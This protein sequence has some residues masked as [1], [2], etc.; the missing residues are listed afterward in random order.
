M[1]F[2]DLGIDGF[3]VWSGLEVRELGPGLNV[4]YG[5]N[6]AGKTTLL[7]F[8]RAVLYGF[9]LERRRKYLPPVRGGQGGGWLVVATAEGTF[10]ITRT[11]RSDSLLGDVTV[12]AADGTVQGG[13]QLHDLLG[14]VDEAIF[15]NVFAVGLEELQELGTLDGTEAAR[16]L[17]GLSAGLDRVSLAE[18]MRELDASRQRLLAADER[19]S[20]IAELS[21]ERDKLCAE[22][23]ELAGSTRRYWQLE[24]GSRRVGVTKSPMP[25]PKRLDSTARPARSNWLMHSLRNG[26][27]ARCSKSKWPHWARWQVFRQTHCDEC[28]ESPTAFGSIDGDWYGSSAVG[29]N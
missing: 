14:D 3:G 17:Y 11:A 26:T 24:R 18:V 7:Q 4:F 29:D 21:A 1:K 27:S 5:P 16:L 9:S 23:E 19:P 2:T 22:I 20:R 25:K 15:Q 13:P 6:E 8:V 12:T 10:D 28:I